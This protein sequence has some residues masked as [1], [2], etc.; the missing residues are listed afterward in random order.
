MPPPPPTPTSI[1]QEFRTT[2]DRGRQVWRM[3][4]RRDKW[5][6]WLAGGLMIVVGASAAGVKYLLGA[7]VD[8]IQLYKDAPEADFFRVAA[9]YLLVIAAIFVLAEILQVVRKYVVQNTTTRIE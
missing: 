6:L 3:V 2:W 1:W 7:L 5:A 9:F 4:A 8:S